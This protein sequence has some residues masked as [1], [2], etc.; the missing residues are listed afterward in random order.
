MTDTNVSARLEADERGP[1]SLQLLHW[2]L[3]ILAINRGCRPIID[4][5]EDK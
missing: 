2:L 1:E 4:G 5:K 3:P